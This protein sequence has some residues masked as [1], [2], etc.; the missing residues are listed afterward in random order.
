[1]TY[2]PQKANNSSAE[3]GSNYAKPTLSHLRQGV[4]KSWKL[5]I[6]I[7]RSSAN[8]IRCT[9]G[10]TIKLPFFEGERLPMN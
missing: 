7:V 5:D 6:K 8:F 1:M 2:N 3:M 4:S 9:E 10:N